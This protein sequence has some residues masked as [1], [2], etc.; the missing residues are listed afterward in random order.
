MLS[1][2]LMFLAARVWHPSRN[3]YL[4]FSQA[5]VAK[6]WLGLP[7]RTQHDALSDGTIA[8]ALLNAYRTIQH[9]TNRIM[10][11][12][13]ATLTAPRIY[14]FSTLNPVIEGCW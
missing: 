1:H 13:R 8:M 7:E 11:M 6:V 9:D 5:H 4:H 10:T 14:G 12:Q 3:I 2:T